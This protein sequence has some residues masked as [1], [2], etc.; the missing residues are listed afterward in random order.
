ML[1]IKSLKSLPTSEDVFKDL[2][3]DP[4]HRTMV[5]SLVKS[6]LEKQTAKKL[7]PSISLNQ[8]LI[9]GKGSGLVI[10][11]HGVP[12]VG[13]TATA[14]AIAQTNKKP[15]FIITCGDLGF[16]PKEVEDSLKDIFRLAN[17]WDCVLLL[18]EAD[19]FLSRRELGD[20]KRNALVS[21]FLRVL[22]YYSGILFLTTNRVGTLDEA[23]K[24]RI[25][26][27]LYYPPLDR[28]QTIDIFKVNIRKLKEI[29]HE[30]EELQAELDSSSKVTSVERP[31]L[32]IDPRS[33]LHYAAWHYDINET[34]PEQRWNGRQIRNAFQIA[35]SLAQFDMN[36]TVLS[37][38]GKARDRLTLN[39]HQFDM[40]AKAVE[41]FESYLYYAT[42][43]TDGDRARKAAIREDEYD[44][45]TTPQKSAY[46][47]PFR[48][49]KQ[50]VSR[51]D[52]NTAS[53][54]PPGHSRE[55]RPPRPAPRD[56]RAPMI[57]NS[58]GRPEHRPLNGSG[59]GGPP[60]RNP[61]AG[62][63][64]GGSSGS[65]A[66]LHYTH[67]SPLP[68]QSQPQPP[69]QPARATNINYRGNNAPG[70]VTPRRNN[71]G[72]HS[73]WDTNTSITA[74][75]TPSASGDWQ[76]DVAYD[77]EDDFGREK[78]EGHDIGDGGNYENDNYGNGEDDLDGVEDDRGYIDDGADGEPYD[79][80]DV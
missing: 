80:Y 52:Q 19:I 11:L 29:I 22:E 12:G 68:G 34:S 5:M 46:N 39:W 27:S 64:P 70:P 1:D 78:D 17:L 43:G 47:P 77:S 44:Y 53:N 25:H 7:R 55:Y 33:I 20:L 16:T 40:V 26:V 15:L 21:V 14:E 61:N 73:G 51:P 69:Q 4:S 58:Q 8:D 48:Q 50:G 62:G 41:K 38:G 18:D 31:Q 63:F 72:N 56:G 32:S 71:L 9:R 66:S 74:P 30:K 49:W 6:H 65:T 67:S 79:D 37:Q 60:R 36:S 13:K 75:R 45:R 24:S 10:L 57:R 3:I 59:R 42:N 23:F 28:D 2:K 76:E 54:F 35:Y